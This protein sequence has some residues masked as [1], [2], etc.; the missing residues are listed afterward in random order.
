MKKTRSERLAEYLSDQ[1]DWNVIQTSYE[2]GRA[3]CGIYASYSKGDKYCKHCGKKLKVTCNSAD[4]LSELE[5]ALKYA[6]K[7]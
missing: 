7:E 6:L 5:D 1:L 2:C 4:V 3:K